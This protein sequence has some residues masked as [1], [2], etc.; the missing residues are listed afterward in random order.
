MEAHRH[1]RRPHEALHTSEAP[2]LLMIPLGVHHAQ[3][4]LAYYAFHKQLPQLATMDEFSQKTTKEDRDAAALAWVTG[5]ESLSSR[6][7]AFLEQSGRTGELINVNDSETLLELV[8]KIA[9][10]GVSRN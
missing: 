8:G 7:A 6:F 1:E 5:D 9:A 2:P 4:I 3:A 10:T